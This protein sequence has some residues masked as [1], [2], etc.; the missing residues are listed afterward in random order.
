MTNDML[1][2]KRQVVHGNTAFQ[3][4]GGAVAAE[5]PV[6]CKVQYGFPQGFARDSAGMQT[7]PTED[8]SLFN[9]R[10]AAVSNRSQCRPLPCRATANHNQKILHTQLSPT[11][12]TRLGHL[13]RREP[14]RPR[15]P[16]CQQ[17]R[18]AS[19][20]PLALPSMESQGRQATRPRK[21]NPSAQRE[22]LI[23]LHGI[24]EQPF[25]GTRRVAN[26][27]GQIIAKMHS[28][29]TQADVW[30]RLFGQKGVHN[31]LVG[32]EAKRQDIVVPLSAVFEGKHQMWGGF[33]MDANFRA[34]ARQP[35]ARAHVKRH[36]R[37]DIMTSD[38]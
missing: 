27:K 8:L 5:E 19:L 20:V 24:V 11:P 32:L 22:R 36:T 12:Y 33:G 25:V 37:L 34:L 16:T 3:A 7:T 14:P 15:V 10:D 17:G 1:D 23:A 30:S 31:A 21:S 29:R 38:G 18:A 2:T 26:T 9:Q 4:V 6:S 28:D 35:F 13:V